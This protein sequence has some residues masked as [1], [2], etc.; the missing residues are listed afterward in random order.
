LDNSS[1]K[2]IGWLHT[3]FHLFASHLR[4]AKR[5]RRYGR[6]VSELAKNLSENAWGYGGGMIPYPSDLT[7]AQRALIE[8]L[9]PGAAKTHCGFCLPVC[10]TYVPR[11][12]EMDSPRGRNRRRRSDHQRNMGGPFRRL[13]GLHGSH[14]GVSLRHGLRETNRSHAGSGNVHRLGMLNHE[15]VIRS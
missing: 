1:H 13:P 15:K 4:M 14:D 10:P 11:N 5:Y 12:E 3:F 8:P 7:A 2:F 9:L 6:N